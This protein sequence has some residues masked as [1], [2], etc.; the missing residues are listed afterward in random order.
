M[1]LAT[2]I[3]WFTILIGN[4]P[5][6]EVYRQLPGIISAGTKNEIHET[7]TNSPDGK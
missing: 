1:K 7:T 2:Y 6:S 4:R 5:K 3:I